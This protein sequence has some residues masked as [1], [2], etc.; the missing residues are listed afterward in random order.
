MLVACPHSHLSSYHIR[1]T[2]FE[3]STLDYKLIE[4]HIFNW[5]YQPKVI[6]SFDMSLIDILSEI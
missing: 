1:H 3:N 6:K 5:G 4:F 2:I